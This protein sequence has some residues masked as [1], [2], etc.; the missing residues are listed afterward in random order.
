VNSKF[1]TIYD[2]SLGPLSK[3]I[4]KLL[5]EPNLIIFDLE[6]YI[7]KSDLTRANYKS[8]LYLSVKKIPAYWSSNFAYPSIFILWVW[9]APII[10]YFPIKMYTILDDFVTF[11]TIFSQSKVPIG[12]AFLVKKASRSFTV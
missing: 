9:K 7:T 12:V 8:N 10:F 5:G 2:V 1:S 11:A 4:Y 3:V 6:L